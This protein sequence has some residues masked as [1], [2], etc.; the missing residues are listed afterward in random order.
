MLALIFRECLGDIALSDEDISYFNQS[1]SRSRRAAT[2]DS[3]RI[4][5]RGVIPFVFRAH[6]DANMIKTFHE[7][8]RVWE[9]H[10]CVQFVPEIPDKGYILFASRDCG[11][12]SYVGRQ[13]GNMPQGLSIGRGCEK[14]GTILHELGHAV[15]F[16]HEMARP[17]RDSYIEINWN[18]IYEYNHDNFEIEP[19][20][21][22]RGVSYDPFSIMHY[23][24][25]IIG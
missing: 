12:C 16:W 20:V 25:G 10:T 19:N 23:G 21:D 22:S 9:H 3:E 15:G 18:N 11:C 24:K 17:D 1:L 13:T 8:M 2:N 14:P 5:P 7:Q 6:W 4:W